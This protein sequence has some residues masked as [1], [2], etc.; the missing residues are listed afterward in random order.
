MSVF[1]VVATVIT[2]VALSGYINCRVVR[3]PDTI[4][5]TAIALLISLVM[6]A[7][8][9]FFPEV[10]AW[11][12]TTVR[13][14]DFPGLIFHGLLGLLLFAGSLHLDVSALTRSRWAILSLA[15]VGVV[16]STVLIGFAFFFSVRWL[17]ATIPLIDCLIFGA[18][19]SPTDAIAVL[20]L[21]RKAGVPQSLLTKITG[22]A[23]FND[24]TGVVVF[25]VLLGISS[26]AQSLD[27][28]SIVTLLVRQVAGGLVFGVAVGFAGLYL[29][30]RINSHVVETLITL[31]MPTGG[32][33]AAEA[34]GVSAPIAAVV[35]GLAVGTL[36]RR[37][38]MTEQTQQRLFGF[39]ELTDDLLNLLLF[40]LIGLELMSLVASARQF[41][42]LAL[43]SI[44][45]VLL[46]RWVS[47]AVPIAILSRV[48][49]F[50]P[51]SIKLMTWA[52]LRG[53]LSVAM[54][55]SLPDSPSRE[56]I[57][58]ATYAVAVFSILVQATTVE[59]LARRWAGR[60]PT[61]AKA[62]ADTRAPD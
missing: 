13:M 15:T 41:L 55:L 6:V 5:I 59:P 12:R 57:V 11:G 35:M 42:G 27:S 29:L 37:D 40:G 43:I 8:G 62:A 3:L 17:G 9:A 45:I 32:Y 30:R 28:A 33:A 61:S 48:E 21:L 22:E 52:G 60:M 50:E 58:G 36:G 18:L 49:K 26:G 34:L 54:A 44:P 46:A 38:A 56:A 20:G 53:A 7:L 10:S 4:G 31:A 14:L 39:W 23:L 19:I 25:L 2:V 51:H 47:V 24:G 16:L 1:N